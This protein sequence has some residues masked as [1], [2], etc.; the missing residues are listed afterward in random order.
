MMHDEARHYVER[1]ATDA[2]VSVIEVGSRRI[3]GEVRDLFPN[4]RYHGIDIQDGPGVDEVADGATFQPSRRVDLVVCCETLEH[5]E[6]WRDIVANTFAMLKKDGR[7]IFTAAG[8]RR[9]PHS[10][11]DGGQLRGHEFYENIDP[12][13]LH[14][15]MTEAGFVGVEFEELGPDVRATGV[16]SG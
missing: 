12:D 1:F 13:E 3:N 16:R 4:A 5:A 8:P 11:I 9:Q 15:L 10:G 14:E 7:V 6:H 2:K